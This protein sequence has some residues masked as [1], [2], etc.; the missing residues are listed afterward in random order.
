MVKV[1]LFFDSLFIICNK[2][3]QY[4]IKKSTLKNFVL[5]EKIEG[6][7]CLSAEGSSV[8]NTIQ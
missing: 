8:K 1:K 7:G 4:F 3:I 2:I 6:K 5:R